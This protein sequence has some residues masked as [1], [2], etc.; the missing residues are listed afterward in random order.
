METLLAAAAL[1]TS[2]AIMGSMVFFGA[3]IAPT[4]FGVLSAQDAGAFVRA[5]FP[6]YYSGFVIASG[7]ATVFAAAAGTGVLAWVLAA[8]TASFAAARY[9]LM[10]AI[11]RARDSGRAK[12]FNRLHGSSVVLNMVQLVALAGVVVALALGTG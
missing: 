7:V 5:V 12:L 9:L 11:N 3:V 8:V 1:T 10:P 2:A 6:R 4:A